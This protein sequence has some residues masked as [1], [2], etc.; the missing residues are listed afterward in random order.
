MV[1]GNPVSATLPVTV[2][3]NPS[4]SFVAT[5]AASGCVPLSVSF[6]DQSTGGGGSAIVGWSWAFG[7][8]GVDISDTASPAHNFT[9]PGVFDI[10]LQVTDANGCDS[11]I[12]VPNMV[13]TSIPPSAVI[14]TT[15][16][17][18]AGCTAPHD[19]TFS[20]SSS[21]SFAAAGPTLTFDWS[22]GNGDSAS[23]ENPPTVT[24]DTN[25]TYPAELIVTDLN[26]CTDTASLW[27]T[28]AQ[29]EAGFIVID[30]INDTV[31]S[32]VFFFDTSGVPDPIFHYGDGTSGESI[33]HTYDTAGTY[34]AMQVVTVGVCSDTAYQTVIVEK[35]EAAFSSTP[36]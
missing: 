30:A 20:G 2:Y 23:I 35:I 25:N 6:L 14:T 26:S 16:T 4:P 24:Y 22:F 11:T 17:P 18:A 9:F 19:V 10:V 21:Q 28:V 12:Q 36:S 1:G 29:P 5:T 13:S 7:D 27:I 32:Q 15:P 8:G 34:I 33:E 31:C 3:G